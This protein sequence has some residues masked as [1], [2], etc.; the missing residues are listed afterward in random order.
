MSDPVLFAPK[1]DEDK[2]DDFARSTMKLIARQMGR[3][4]GDISPGADWHWFNANYVADGIWVGSL[5]VFRFDVVDLLFRPTKHPVIAALEEFRKEIPEG[6]DDFILIFQV[7]EWGRMFISNHDFQDLTA[8]RVVIRTEPLW[9]AP[10]GSLF[11]RWNTN[12]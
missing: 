10:L 2:Q 7:Y 1:S 11:T 4:P 5:R 3:S 8:L 9:V 6:Y 12:G